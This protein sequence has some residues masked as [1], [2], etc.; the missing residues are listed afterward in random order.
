MPITGTMPVHRA[1][2]VLLALGALG[3]LAPG[4]S[5]SPAGL[6][7]IRSFALALGDGAADRDLSGYDLVVV[8]G[9]ARR[10]AWQAAARRLGGPRLPRRRDDRA[11]PLVVQAAP[12]PIGWSYWPDWGEW[13]AD[14]SRP[15]FRDLIAGRVAPAI[16]RK[17]FDG[18]FL[19]NVDMIESTARQRAGMLALV[20][21]LARAAG[22]R[23][24]PERRRRSSTR[25]CR[26]LD[27]WN[28]EDVTRTYDFD[29]S[30]TSP[31]LAPTTAAARSPRCAGC[32]RAASSS[33]RPTTSPPAT[34]R[35]RTAA[36][37]R[38]PARPA[39]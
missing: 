37:P 24:R 17:G 4:A 11:L 30:A 28:R 13:Y 16:L 31:W 38:R 3:T 9:D 12:S 15:G 34:R 20:R 18:L 39:R 23:V 14:V 27:G 21:R 33:P 29:A 19:D 8:D 2:I 32:G 6:A 1:L 25:S 26:Y 35:P 36:R 22:L 7:Q 5:A 10:L